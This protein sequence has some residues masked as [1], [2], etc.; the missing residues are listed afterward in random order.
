VQHLKAHH[1]QPQKIQAIK[2]PKEKVPKVMVSNNVVQTS[3]LFP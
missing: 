1:W 2:N 3:P